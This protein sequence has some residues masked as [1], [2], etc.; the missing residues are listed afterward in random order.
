[1]L[2]QTNSFLNAEVKMKTESWSQMGFPELQSLTSIYLLICVTL[3]GGLFYIRNGLLIMPC[4]TDRGL[5]SQNTARNT[6]LL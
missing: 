4:F 6:G 1:M 2:L 5:V 3:H